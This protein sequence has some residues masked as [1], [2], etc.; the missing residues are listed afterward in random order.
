M[1]VISDNACT[2]VIT[3][4]RISIC[5]T[6]YNNHCKTPRPRRP[7]PPIIISPTYGL[8]LCAEKIVSKLSLTYETFS[9]WHWNYFTYLKHTPSAWHWQSIEV[10]YLHPQA[11]CYD[12]HRKMGTAA[13]WG[14]TK[15]PTRPLHVHI[16]S[17]MSPCNE[18][19]RL[20]VSI[21]TWERHL[22]TVRAV[23]VILL[24]RL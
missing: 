3:V 15:S 24:F 19:F 6:W 9:L 23:A 10:F 21:G 2:A 18:L 4:H 11:R 14:T 17:S 16:L 13:A 22:P 12:Q 8:L 1:A 5:M 20:S 7:T